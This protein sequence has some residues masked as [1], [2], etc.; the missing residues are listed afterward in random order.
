MR[1]LTMNLTYSADIKYARLVCDRSGLGLNINADNKVP[2]TDGSFIYLPP[3][4]PMW[5][6]NSKEYKN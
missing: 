4:N 5:S 2:H 6:K 3:L 1:E